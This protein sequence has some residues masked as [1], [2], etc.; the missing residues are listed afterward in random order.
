MLQSL[1]VTMLSSSGMGPC[2][3]LPEHQAHLHHSA[4]AAAVLSTNSLL[5]SLPPLAH[6]TS[7]SDTH[8]G[9]FSSRANL[10]HT[11]SCTVL[12]QSIA[13]QKISSENGKYPMTLEGCR[14]EIGRPPLALPLLLPLSPS[15]TFVAPFPDF[16]PLAFRVCSGMVWL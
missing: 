6:S 2:W 15:C 10:G 7:S 13:S 16:F 14:R 3:Q 11:S 8:S 4:F 5:P 12:R 1:R 9:V